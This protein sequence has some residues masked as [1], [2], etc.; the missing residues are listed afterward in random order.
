M[1]TYGIVTLMSVAEM[2]RYVVYCMVI[3]DLDSFDGA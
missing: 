2:G 1:E 3:F